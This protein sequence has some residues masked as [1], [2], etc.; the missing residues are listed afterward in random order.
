[1]GVPLSSFNHCFRILGLRS[2][3]LFAQAYLTGK[4]KNVCLPVA[5]L[6]HPV[7][8][9]VGTTDVGTFK[10]VFLKDEYDWEINSQPQCIIDAGANIGLTSVLFANRYPQATIFSIEPEV[11]NFEMLCKNAQPYPNIVPIHAALWNENTE[12]NLVDPGLGEWGFQTKE[13]PAPGQ[14]DQNRGRVTAITVDRILEQHGVEQVDLLKMDIEGAETTVLNDAQAWIDSVSILV[15][16]LHERFQP[17]CEAAFAKATEKF[18]IH[19][20]R[21]PLVFASRAA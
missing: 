7:T 3:S 8:L 4:P 11:E 14:S 13:E 20:E 2:L 19:K 16:E 17:G 5:G 12:I 15:A 10:Q 9:R 21:G 18:E 1:M 6:K